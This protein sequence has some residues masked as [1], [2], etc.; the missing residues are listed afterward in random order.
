MPVIWIKYAKFLIR[1]KLIT[2][3][4]HAFDNA[5]KSLPAT[6]HDI[7]WKPYIDWAKSVNCVEVARH[8]L[9]RYISYNPDAREECIEFLT[10]N[11]EF[12]EAALE[13]IKVI[14][15]AYHRQ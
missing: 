4:R 1:Q 2:K 14:F 5:L 15:P 10:N 6:Q 8:V 12:N 9:Q 13:L 11:G 7:I 3:T